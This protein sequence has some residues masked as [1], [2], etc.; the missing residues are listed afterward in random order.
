MNS[1][2]SPI[3]FT[4]A[5]K[6]IVGRRKEDGY[7]LVDNGGGVWEFVIEQG[8]TRRFLAF[9]KVPTKY[10][11]LLGQVTAISMF[12]EIEKEAFKA[13]DNWQIKQQLSTSALKTFN[14]LIDEL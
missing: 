1:N 10:K 7:R 4:S 5:I 13:I 2:I 14:E 6:T 3:A 11:P 9:V 8:P 12:N